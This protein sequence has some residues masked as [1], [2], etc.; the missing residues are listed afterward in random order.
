MK[1]LGGKIVRAGSKLIQTG[2]ECASNAMD[3]SHPGRDVQIVEISTT[4]G[5]KKRLVCKVNELSRILFGDNRTVDLPVNR[6]KQVVGEEK[7]GAA[8]RFASLRAAWTIF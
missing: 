7:G 1:T 4:L 2:I 3:Q 8:R 6:T 5:T